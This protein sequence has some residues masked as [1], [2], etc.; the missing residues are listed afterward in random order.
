VELL[1]RLQDVVLAQAPV[2]LQ[3]RQAQDQ[4]C[5]ELAG[6]IKN[7]FKAFISLE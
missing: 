6:L 4:V 2:H 1:R 3:A 5:G 7:M